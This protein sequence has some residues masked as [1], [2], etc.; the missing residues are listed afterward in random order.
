M[1]FRALNLKHFWLD[2]GVVRE[3]IWSG[4]MIIATTIQMLYGNE[5]MDEEIKSAF[6]QTAL[7]QNA[8]AEI[9]RI[10]ANFAILEVKLVKLIYFLIGADEETTL[11]VCSEKSFSG[12][13]DLAMSLFIKRAKECSLADSW[14]E[15]FRPVL[16][17]VSA[18]EQKRNQVVHSLWGFSGFPNKVIRTKYTS[19]RRNGLSFQRDEMKIQDLNR[20][21]NQIS[22]V[23]FDI[24][25][26]CGEVFAE[27]RDKEI[28]IPGLDESTLAVK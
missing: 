16:K 21:A 18:V 1:E 9:G 11:I 2:L 28:L 8:L 24:H 26:C 22:A 27:F 13:Q 6:C 15:R 19:K 25:E 7:D 14:P 17:D 20:I 10:T 3:D 4:N 12:L 5:P 23:A